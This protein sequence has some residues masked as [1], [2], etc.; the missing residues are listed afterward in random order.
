[1]H[2]LSLLESEEFDVLVIG[3][4]VTGA[5]VALDA[6]ARGYKVALVEK[7]DFASGTSSKSTKLVHG[8]IRYLPNFDFALVREAL[9]ERGLLLR[10]AP[11]LVH[12]IGFVL[13][14]YKGDRHPVGLPFTT[15]WGI[16]L[17]VVMDIGLW[18]YD[19][20]AGRLN[21]K[22]HRRL[23]RQEVIQLAPALVRLFNIALFGLPPTF[24]FAARM[25][26]GVQ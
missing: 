14:I 13:P 18:F 9:V 7:N 19:A 26:Y 25:M 5:G 11:F 1:M 22:R 12:P 16:G 15:P 10:N 20:L 3:G 23:S 8:G 17:G 4:G 24:S 6:A 2:N 21:V